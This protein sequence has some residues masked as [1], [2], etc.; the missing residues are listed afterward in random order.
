MT[1]E[2]TQPPRKLGVKQ[3]AWCAEKIPGFDDA[4]RRAAQVIADSERIK[5]EMGGKRRKVA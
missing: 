3:L 5:R 4:Q 2:P 1:G